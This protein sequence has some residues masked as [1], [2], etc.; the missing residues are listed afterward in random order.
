[1]NETVLKNSNLFEQEIS[2][3]RWTGDQILGQLKERLEQLQGQVLPGRLA[4]QVRDHQEPSTRDDLLLDAGGALH[5]L[6]DEA[7]QLGARKKDRYFSKLS[8]ALGGGGLQSTEV[9]YLFLT[10]QPLV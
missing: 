2:V 1:M 10:K 6:A 5:Q 7:H 3:V 9:A 8:Y 4:Q